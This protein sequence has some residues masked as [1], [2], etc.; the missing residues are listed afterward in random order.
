MEEIV[1]LFL[2]GSYH[3]VTYILGAMPSP[4][5]SISSVVFYFLIMCSMVTL[6]EIQNL[7]I[8]EMTVP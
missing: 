3:S 5:F 4:H 7:I 1:T 2:L 6:L 8:A